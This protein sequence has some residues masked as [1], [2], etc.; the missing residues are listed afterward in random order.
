MISF[1]K[2]LELFITKKPQVTLEITLSLQL[3]KIEKSPK[4]HNFLFFI[5][6]P[7]E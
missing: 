2:Y 3:E 5:S 6:H 7:K 1:L 4:V